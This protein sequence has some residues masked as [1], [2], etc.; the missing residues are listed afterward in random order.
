VIRRC[1]TPPCFRCNITTSL[2]FCCFLHISEHT[3]VLSLQILQ[4]YTS[5]KLYFALHILFLQ[6]LMSELQLFQNNIMSYS[7]HNFHNNNMPHSMKKPAVYANAPVFKQWPN[8]SQHH[9]AAPAPS[10]SGKCMKQPCKAELLS[11][12][13]SFAAEN[14]RSAAEARLDS[15]SKF[16]Q[17]PCKT[18]VSTG[19]C[20]YGER[21]ESSHL[22][23]CCVTKSKHSSHQASS[24]TTRA[25]CATRRTPSRA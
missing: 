10:S 22:F 14:Y 3:T 9:V 21:C 6:H 7:N 8:S 20:P 23:Q 13:G 4:Y 24:C 19:S 16:R 15:S 1:V 25:C 11:N 2:L 5:V 12:W 18:L 17:L